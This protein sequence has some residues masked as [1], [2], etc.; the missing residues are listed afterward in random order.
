MSPSINPER[1][2]QVRSV[3]DDLVDSDSVA[4]EQ[5]LSAL[6]QSDPDLASAV[7]QL[8]DAD[9]RADQNLA[10]VEQAFSTSEDDDDIDPL[11]LAGR[12]ISHFR[13]IELLGGGGMGVVYKAEDLN[14]GRTAA[15]K[16]PLP[17]RRI[18]RQIRQ[19]FLREARSAA[20]VDHP[21]LCSIFEA[22]ETEDG[23]L[24]IAM[25]LYQ[26]ETLKSRLEREH[27]L[28]ITDALGI[29]RQIAQ[30]LSAAHKAGIIHR[31]LK[32][33][34][35]M[36]LEDGTVKILDFGLAK[37]SDLTITTSSVRV[38]TA[39]YMAPEQIEGAAMDGRV[40]LWALGVVLYEMI[41]GQRPFEGTSEISI[42]HSILH[43]PPSAPS[44][45]RTDISAALENTIL[46]LLAKDRDDRF[47]SAGELVTR[48]DTFASI[49]VREA[50][51]N[52]RWPPGRPFSRL[53]VPAVIAGVAAIVIVS[54]MLWKARNEAPSAAPML[55][56]VVLP[57]TFT[58]DSASTYIATGIGSDV[59][60]LF[61]RIKAL[62]V[63]NKTA[64]LRPPKGD[65]AFIFA[66]TLG[67]SR[68]V[69]AEVERSGAGAT[70]VARIADAN[71]SEGVPERRIRIESAN[72][73]AAP[74]A[75]TR[76][77][78]DVL[79]VRSST[80]E[81]AVLSKTPTD[82]SNAYDWYL[83]GRHAE[84]TLLDPE[85]RVNAWLGA[86][87]L[88]WRAREIDPQF[89]FARA[90]LALTHAQ[91]A[92]SGEDQS[93]TRRE[94]ARIEAE[95]A[96]RIQPD[97]PDAHIAIA[98]YWMI[99]RDDRKALAS[100]QRAMELAPSDPGIHFDAAE[101]HRRI[102]RWEDAASEFERALDLEPD[103]ARA[104]EQAALSYS[105]M[106]RFRDSIRMWNRAL[107]IRP[108]NY[109]GWSIRGQVYLR[110]QGQVDT[111]AAD[112]DRIPRSWDQ[113]GARTNTRVTVARI[114]RRF[115]D[116]LDALD[117]AR[118]FPN[119]GL[120]YRP[121][122]LLRGQL[123]GEM[124][125]S[126]R[127]R[128]HFRAAEQ[129]MR[130]TVAHQPD[131][132]GAHIALGLAY[133]GLGKARLAKAEARRAMELAPLSQNAMV[134]TAFAAGAAEIYTD[135]GDTDEALKLLRLL[136][137]MPAGREVS[138]PLLRVDPRWDP[139]RKDPR[140]ER[141]LQQYSEG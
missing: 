70:I 2:A 20:K 121:I 140:F 51:P 125:D 72:L 53:T 16:F 108:D 132:P 113:R 46:K 4:R 73:Q 84:Q 90:R 6:A 99:R 24:F 57:F 65:S 43:A 85:R 55:A 68:I 66:R 35:V 74:G 32:P 135:I 64:M 59:A 14:L 13:I 41:V 69:T 26:G 130:D 63:V 23:H 38:G 30:G 76:R 133:A 3:F 128:R 104:A 122:P 105:R 54:Y 112:L 61:K 120:L 115:A 137:A 12:T 67:V 44:A 123:Y 10:K 27:K 131:N 15:L 102:G 94:Q 124:G 141:L 80:A 31:D 25:P 39:T 21:N 40:D 33:A 1:W 127:A 82:N 71:T 98:Y 106:R 62:H 100:L 129:M 88:Y 92:L 28:P 36:L 138:V 136:L 45:Q 111:L 118:V 89:A 114:R 7:R 83:R 78:L 97:L 87:P 37:V 52:K 18:S 109:T 139:L 9:E 86:Q 47:A 77:I 95:A 81:R 75:V 60:T 101:V 34:N 96:L 42:A 8:L 126:T 49:P 5:E 103:N 50:F 93:E 58:G 134:A 117:E 91:I 11:H 29:A 107:T 56:I 17:D 119:D 22:G 110:W 116:A 79:R 19:R 48:I